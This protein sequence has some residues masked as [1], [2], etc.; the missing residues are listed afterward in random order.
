MIEN[1][2]PSPTQNPHFEINGYR[3]RA[4]IGCAPDEHGVTQET[5]A[6]LGAP[7][8]EYS[9]SGGVVRDGDA[10]LLDTRM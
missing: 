10:R 1:R 8:G 7:S 5:I 6:G 9:P 4:Q 2:M 3:A